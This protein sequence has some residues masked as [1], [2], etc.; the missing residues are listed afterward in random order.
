MKRSKKVKRRPYN[1]WG[2]ITVNAGMTVNK[3]VLSEYNARVRS[4][5][6]CE[7]LPQTLPFMDKKTADDNPRV[8]AKKRRQEIKEER[9]FIAIGG[10]RLYH[11]DFGWRF[12]RDINDGI[13]LS[14]VYGNKEL[15]ILALRDDNIAWMRFIPSTTE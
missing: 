10:Y 9:F 12:E 2:R 5:S 7:A 8:Q 4:I 13:V 6:V 11:L 14:Q 1:R 3:L 15:A